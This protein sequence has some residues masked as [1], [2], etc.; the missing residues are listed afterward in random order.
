[1]V[2]SLARELETDIRR[3]CLSPGHK[4]L[5]AEEGAKLFGTSVATANRAMQLLA[6]REVVVRRRNSGT[7]VGPALEAVTV[8][9]VQ[10]VSILAPAS[11]RMNGAMRFDLLI[12]G[13]V[14]S[15]PDVED[16]RVSYVPAEGSVTFVQKLLEPARDSGGLM[17]VIAISSPREVYR[18]LGENNYPLV[19]L[20]SLYPDQPY[21]SI[22][23]DEHGAGQMLT[24]Y[25]VQRGHRRLAVF[26]DSESQPGDNLFR[27]GVSEV[28]TSA[29]LPHNALIW[30]TPGHDPS[31]LRAQATDLLSMREIPTGILVKLPHLADDIAGIIQ[32]HGLR[33]PEDIEIVFKGLGLGETERSAFPYACPN[34]LSRK[35]A[36]LVG[37][38]LA[39]VRQG[40]LLEQRTVIIPYQMCESP[41]IGVVG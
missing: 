17:G 2:L 35:F 16:V 9:S 18:Y 25:L 26:S 14:A 29:K 13:I 38:M 8:G 36:E 30:R 39:R 6:E 40:S 3:R 33:V 12:Q 15:M 34:M 37:Q 24:N 11:T 20:G 19:V 21:P 7:F 5:T 23:T 4:Y 31:V 27:D 22:D 10:T 28:L 41:E 32:E 1:M